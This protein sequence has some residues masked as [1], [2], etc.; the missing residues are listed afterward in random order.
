[1]CDMPLLRLSGPVSNLEWLA[2]ARAS[3][4]V[5]G[6]PVFGDCSSVHQ[7]CTCIRSTNIFKYLLCLF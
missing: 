6:Q 5:D 7:K 3:H 2:T 1:M 4:D